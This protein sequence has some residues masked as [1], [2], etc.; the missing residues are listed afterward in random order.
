MFFVQYNA[1]KTYFLHNSE[2]EITLDLRKGRSNMAITE[3]VEKIRQ[4]YVN[5]KPHISYERAWSW[6]KSFQR[7]EG[8]PNIIRVAQAFKDTCSELSVNIWEGELVVGTSGE[9]RKC[10]ILTPE[11]GWLWINDEIDTFPERSQDP[12]EVT[13]EQAKFIRE[14][15]FP[16]WKGKSIEEAFLAR[17]SEATKKIGVDTGFLDTDSKWRNG[18]GEISADYI[19]V[20][21]PKGYASIKKEAE[22][23][24]SQLNEAIPEEKK[25]IDFYKSIIMIADGMMTLG[26]RYSEKATEMAAVEAD[27]KRKAELEEIAQICATVPANPPK[28]F[29]E[30]IQF[31]WFVQLGGILS[32]NPL[33]WNPGRFDQYMY[34]YY[35]ADLKAGKIDYDTALEYV[36]CLWLKYSEWAWTISK[37]TASFF[38]GYTN[39]ENLTIGG[40]KVDGTDA[41]NTISY[42]ALQATKECMTHQPTLS[43]R[44]HPDCPPEFME[45]VTELV[46]TGCGFPAKPLIS[47]TGI[48]ITIATL[49]IVSATVPLK[50][51][52]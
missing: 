43:C 10:A 14:N 20:L 32:E 48:R 24:L 13:P 22:E 46:S 29:R 2:D 12:Y 36:E 35:E 49:R 11:F 9:Y 5:T 23:H 16:Y 21:L 4:N 45:A 28:S 39:F 50:K 40:T 18:V 30:A 1:Q 33:A 47:G 8:L 52:P 7:T 3:R 25:K 31:V 41:T 17:T 38:A 15:I 51:S 27:P 42:M 6:T 34:P 44:I 26:R 37:N 19:D